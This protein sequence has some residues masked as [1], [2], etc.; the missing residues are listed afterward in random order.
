MKREGG[1]TFV[2][3]MVVIAILSI[4]AVTAIPFFG[5]Y[6]QRAYGSQAIVLSKQIIDA[7]IMY[8]L[9]N[10]EFVPGGKTSISIFSDSDPSSKE[11]QKIIKNLNIILPLG[12]NFDYHF[13]NDPT[14]PSGK[15]LKVVISAPF[16]I[17]K[18]GRPDVIMKLFYDGRTQYY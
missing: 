2:E 13:Y 1:F 11:V 18:N 9:E 16:P 15:C 17:F 7:E 3:L 10:D 14:D 5:T 6:K 12:G 4:L 8:F